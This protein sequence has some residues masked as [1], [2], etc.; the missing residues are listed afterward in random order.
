[1][2]IA[3]YKAS[4]MGTIKNHPP[5]NNTYRTSNIQQQLGLTITKAYAQLLRNAEIPIGNRMRPRRRPPGFESPQSQSISPH[6]SA[7]LESHSKYNITR[8]YKHCRDRNENVMSS[9]FCN[10]FTW[11]WLIRYRTPTR[12]HERLIDTRSG[13]FLGG[14]LLRRN[15]K[16]S[17]AAWPTN[18]NLLVRCYVSIVIWYDR[19]QSGTKYM[20]SDY[21]LKYNR[22]LSTYTLR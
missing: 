3:R 5:Q 12:R 9:G 14:I 11:R 20:R 22:Y 21:L 1:M 8:T 13:K 6:R 7:S 15:R 2:S 10:T 17:D 18:T 4:I 19:P 16:Y